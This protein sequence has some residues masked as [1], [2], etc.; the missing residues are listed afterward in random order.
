MGWTTTGFIAANRSLDE[1]LGALPDV[2]TRTGEM[3]DSE[4]AMSSVL[5]PNFAVAQV[6]SHVVFWDPNGNLAA[7]PMGEFARQALSRGG[8]LLAFTLA[9]VESRY[10]VRYYVDGALRRGIAYASGRQVE[11]HGEPLPEEQDIPAP[12]WGYDE[13]W[14]FTLVRKL[15]GVAFRALDEADY[16]LL[17]MG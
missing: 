4:Q 5:A 2:F 3:V 11:Q 6:G 1:V 7:G 17:A 14:V 16:E 9:S 15:A 10:G 13:D 12:E 8:W